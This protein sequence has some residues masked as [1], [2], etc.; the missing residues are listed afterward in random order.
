MS[1]YEKLAIVIVRVIGCC[2]AI[3]A[4]L[5]V[6]FAFVHKILFNDSSFWLYLAASITYLI[7]GLVLFALSKPLAALIA[8]RL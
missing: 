3:Y 8:R 1:H 2:V 5:G 4:L 7:V 6:A